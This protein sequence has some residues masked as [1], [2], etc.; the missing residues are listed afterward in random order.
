MEDRG[1]QFADGVYE[2]WSV[3]DGRL[4]DSEGHFTRLSRSLRELSI[5][6]PMP[7]TALERVL[8]EGG[9]AKRA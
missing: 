8:G 7:R 3:F 4:A 1:L 5:A 6:E 2:V 9:A